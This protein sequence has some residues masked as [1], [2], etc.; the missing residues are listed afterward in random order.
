MQSLSASQL[1]SIAI[2]GA[3]SKLQED[4]KVY[5]AFMGNVLTAGQGQAPCRQAVIGA[6]LSNNTICTTINKVCA[7]GMKSVMLSSD[8]IRAS[9]R[10]CADKVYLAGGFESMT[11][12][13]HYLFHRG[14]SK[15]KLGH[16]SI[17]LLDG[18]LHDGLWDVYNDQHMGICAEKCAKDYSISRDEQD[19]YAITSYQRAQKAVEEGKFSQDIVP[20]SVVSEKG[21]KFILDKDEEPFSVDYDK[22]SKLRPAFAS[23][24]SVT[25][26]NSSSLNDGAAAMIVMSEA[27]AKNLGFSPLARII[28]YGDAAQLPQ[29]FTTTPTL[30]VHEAL[31]ACSSKLLLQDIEYHEINEA[32][33]VV[34]LANMRLMNLDISRV[35]VYGG[36]VALGHPIGMSGAR[37]LGNLIKV[38]EDKDAT[39]GC[40][41]IC[42]G[43][44]GASAMIIERM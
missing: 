28:G 17:S 27:T 36:S 2:K 11:N 29:D 40:A 13:P 22:M 14:E 38:L 1:G 5:E 8:A 37:I 34:A 20:V 7:S 35:N 3:L 19:A 42:N 23:P 33:A 15:K 18:C 31:K 39:I 26:A 43:G 41:S 16:I 21:E 9:S 6:G 32:F 25:A 4:V 12:A 44:G 24:G 30:A 10:N